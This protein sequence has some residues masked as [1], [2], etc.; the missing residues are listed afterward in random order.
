MRK[1]KLIE[2]PDGGMIIDESDDGSFAEPPMTPEERRRDRAGTASFAKYLE[3]R[4][5]PD[6]PDKVEKEKAALARHEERLAAI[7]A[8]Y[9][10]EVRERSPEEV[11]RVE[12]WQAA[13]AKFSKERRFPEIEDEDEREA[14]ALANY[15]Q[16][17][18]AIDA[19]FLEEIRERMPEEVR[20]AAAQQAASAKFD[21]EKNALEIK[22][23]YERF[24]KAFANYRAALEAIDVQCDKEKRERER[25]EQHRKR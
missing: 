1:A 16:A 13:F 25:A 21:E 14:K 2:T 5:F 20:R 15:S 4:P 24:S 10:K 17:L 9:E 23:E 12:A 6:D 19:R 7:E 8:Q 22:N 3:E 18:D 11:R